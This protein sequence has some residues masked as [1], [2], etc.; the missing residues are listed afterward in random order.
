MRVFVVG[1]GRCGSC[2]FY[3][4]ATTIRGMTAGHESRG[5]VVHD[6]QFADN[7][8]EVAPQMVIGIPLMRKRY[9]DAKWIILRREKRACVASLARQCW[10]S[11]QSFAQQWY[12][13]DHP[14]DVMLAVPQFYDAVNA[15]CDAL[16][17]DARVVHAENIAGE[18]SGVCQWLGV[19]YDQPTAAAI[20]DRAYNPGVKRGRDEWIERAR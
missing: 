14:A 15:L 3:Q 9:P 17:P 18:W 16:L 11:M 13:A 4:A 19:D 6:W 8:I 2:T 12:L 10:P 5:G 20:M 1:T 7:H